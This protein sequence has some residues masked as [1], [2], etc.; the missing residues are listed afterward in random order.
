MPISMVDRTT[1]T[2]GPP[3]I[4]QDR[5]P[6]LG[7]IF[8][9]LMLVMLLGALDQTI[10]STALPTIVGDLNGLEHM[11]WVI[12]AYT[13]ASTIAMPVYGKLG[14]LI[15]R[16][17]LF[18]IA[19]VMFLL[20]SALCGISQ[21]II[22][23][24]V[25]RFLQGLGGGGL[26]IA[27]QTII[28]DVVP[29]RERAKFM[30][31]MGAVF[32]LASVVGPLVGGWLTDGP[33]WRWVFWINLPLGLLGLT[34]AAMTI[35]LPRM[36]NTKPIDYAGIAFM[37]SAVTCLILVTCWG[38]SE[39]AWS[40]APILG[41]IAA[42][43]VL[44]V[45]FVM[46]ELRAAEPLIPMRLFRNRVFTVTTVMGLFL[47]V[48]MFAAIG[49]LPTYLQMVYGKSA[50]ASGLLLIPMVVGILITSTI[51]AQRVGKTGRY[52]AMTIVGTL[53]IA[54]GLTLLSTIEVD[55]PIWV[56]CSWI[57]VVGAGIGLFMQILLLVVQNSVDP[58]EIGTATSANNFF[59]EIGATIG[60]TA[61]GTAF[62]NRLTDRLFEVLPAN[63]SDLVP[64]SAS[65]L[66]PAIVRAIPEPFRTGIVNSYAESLVPLFFWLVPLMLIG[67]LLAFLL[68]GTPLE[69]TKPAME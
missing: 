23:L 5:A 32:G 27:S 29:V 40:S 39:Y 9:S 59:R 61:I 4:D 54:G 20:G 13:L 21:S 67:T 18:L 34:V 35:H 44:S 22:T 19:I 56:V 43:V 3:K 55:T 15:G 36:R 60:V 42:T 41:L 7:W 31:P 51:S 49:Y 52:K 62:T 69:S 47:G 53:V 64:V 2:P 24:S 1:E 37:S 11:A 50:T 63:A 30:A 26:M 14:D 12:T 58:R 65:G 6:H 57:G 33:G 16:K 8:A 66:T 48:G 68:D 28:A 45:L 17:N 46:V 38:G 25:F 10:V